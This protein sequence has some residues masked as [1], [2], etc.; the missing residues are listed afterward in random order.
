V[1]GLNKHG[2]NR[3]PKTNQTNHRPATP[4]NVQLKPQE[5]CAGESD[6]KPDNGHRVESLRVN[7]LVIGASGASVCHVIPRQLLYF[8]V[9]LN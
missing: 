8:R 1:E 7:I 3:K 2:P 4:K 9:I 6:T 5:H